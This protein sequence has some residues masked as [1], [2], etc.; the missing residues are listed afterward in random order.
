VMESLA[1]A[2][3]S[4]QCQPP[5]RLQ[6]TLDLSRSHSDRGKATL[7]HE[8]LRQ[9]DVDPRGEGAPLDGRV[10][11]LEVGLEPCA[12]SMI[13]SGY[14]FLALASVVR[15]S[16]VPA[17]G[18]TRL[19][20]LSVRYL[21]FDQRGILSLPQLRDSELG[22]GGA[23]AVA[24]GLIGKDPPWLRA[25]SLRHNGLGASG[26]SAVFEA[27]QRNR[28]LEVRRAFEV[29]GFLDPLQQSDISP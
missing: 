29:V 1:L 24:R 5:L 11:A 14:H 20:A 21:V 9:P 12:P 16:A 10:C 19:V 26:A 2:S 17:S 15:M 3:V 18:G 6:V 27:L 8:L 22:D 25:L 4:L 7:V 13:S 23:E 28:H